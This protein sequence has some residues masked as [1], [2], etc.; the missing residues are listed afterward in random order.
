MTTEVDPR[1]EAEAQIAR[2]LQIVCDADCTLDCLQKDPGNGHRPDCK[3]REYTPDELET[4]FFALGTAM[5][6]LAKMPGGKEARER[7]YHNA[8]DQLLKRGRQD[9]LDDLAKHKDNMKL[10]KEHVRKAFGD[11]VDFAPGTSG[12]AMAKVVEL[13]LNNLDELRQKITALADSMTLR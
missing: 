4:L 13:E 11:D 10:A 12:Y 5:T 2:A 7:F 6:Q 9:I 3:Q 8:Q 1:T